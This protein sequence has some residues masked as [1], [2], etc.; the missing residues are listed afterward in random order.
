MMDE[1]EIDMH[2]V[3]AYATRISWKMPPP[4]SDWTPAFSN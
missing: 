1:Q 3:A 2:K 4:T